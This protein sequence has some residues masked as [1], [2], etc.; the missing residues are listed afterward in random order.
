[1]IDSGLPQSMWEFAVDAAVHVYNRTPHKSI[2]YQTPLERFAPEAKSHVESLRRFGCLGFI[3]HPKPETKFEKR[4]IKA[5]LVGYTT[6]GYLLW[7]PT[8]RKIIE[9][10]HVRFNEKRVYK[11]EYKGTSEKQNQE[12]VIETD[13]ISWNEQEGQE[14]NRTPQEEE[15]KPKKRG[16]PRK[17][18]QRTK[19]QDQKEKMEISAPM[20][21]SKRKREAE[22]QIRNVS[23]NRRISEKSGIETNTISEQMQCFAANSIREPTTYSEAMQTDEREDWKRAVK[24]ELNSMKENQ[25]WKLVNKSE[26][27]ERVANVID[28]RW[29]FKRKLETD[30]SI[31]FKAR[32]VIRGFKDKNQYDLSETYAPVS[33][34][35]VIR[36]TLAVANKYNLDVCQLDVKTAFLNGI[37][38]EE[39]Y[40]KIPDGMD[41]DNDE[42][43]TK[44]C[45]LER[46][47]YGLKTSPKKWNQRFGV[48]M[49]KL[50]LENDLHE[51][52][53][54]T[55]RKEGRMV[56]LVLYVDD[57][58]LTG[59]DPE[60]LAEIKEHLN[61]VFE[62]K[63]LG[64][65]K[66]FLGMEIARS[67]EENHMIINQPKYIEQMLEKFNM[68]ECKP[69][70]TPMVTRQVTNRNRRKEANEENDNL[71]TEITGAPYREAIGSL[72]Y[73]A[74]ATRPD[75]SFAVN[76]LARRQSKPTEED[77]K[78]VKRVFRYLRGTPNKGLEFKG[79][80]ENLEGF[81]DASFRDNQEDSTSSAGYIVRLFGDVITWRSHKQ[82]IV[83]QSTC[84]AEYLAMSESCAELISLDKAIRCIIGKTFYPITLWCDNQA[85]KEC[86]KKE[87]SHKLKTF[88]NSVETVREQL[89]EREKNGIRKSIAENHGDF[90]KECVGQGKI[91]VSWIATKENLADCMT[92]PLALEAHKSL[93]DRFM[94]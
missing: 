57:I 46:A 32:L 37:L 86:T 90:I 19:S 27:S 2:E 48:E 36:A 3:R 76:Y 93:T 80:E 25:V 26:I 5:V 65:P 17:S 64:E 44:L 45:K 91:R 49:T 66:T 55:W 34:L 78:N 18:Q 29:V 59:N 8:S 71:V 41:L 7:H 85:A 77:W 70:S 39:I 21:R 56:T 15:K 12:T 35:P 81:T 11:D 38:E 22:A 31:R 9:S 43:R 92:K 40:M 13:E 74:N 62:M 4:A 67:R 42:S 58:L 88:D 16:R 82:S 51:P 79:K 30:G 75:I 33:R 1:M 50:G 73:L 6:T 23:S 10:R 72:M 68:A 47:L 94:T 84:Q 53:L 89:R 87:G 24:E 14:T 83:T 60:K 28:S 69:Q 63:N 61:R 54:Y 52:C 20:T